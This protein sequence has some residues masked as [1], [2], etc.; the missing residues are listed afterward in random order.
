[1]NTIWIEKYKPSTFNEYIDHNIIKNI[2]IKLIDNNNFHNLILYGPP[3]IGKTTI[4][5]ICAKYIYGDNYKQHILELNGSDERGINIV[6]ENIHKYANTNT[7]YTNKFKLI[8]LDEIDSMTQDA[9]NALKEII[10]SY[11]H[12][13]KFCLICNFINKLIYPLQS[14][15]II[16]RL[17][18]IKYKNIKKYIKNI[19]KNENIDYNDEG[20]KSIIQFSGGDIRKSCNNLHSVYLSYNKITKNNVYECLGIPKKFEINNLF[21]NLKTKNLNENINYFNKLKYNKGY[22]LN[23]LIKSITENILNKNLDDNILID[24]LIDI[25]KIEKNLCNLGTEVIQT[26]SFMSVLFKYKNYL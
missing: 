19:I 24:I 3:G 14:C 16:F 1:M 10:E 9:Q 6:R 18:P 17:S 2:I 11:E 23:D 13:V 5:H 26:F 20:L 12:N 8:I 25:A 22:L 21:K 15:C 4:I 7:I